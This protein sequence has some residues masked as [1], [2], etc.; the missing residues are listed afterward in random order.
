MRLFQKKLK[1]SS[2][3]KVTEKSAGNPGGMAG[4]A[5]AFGVRGTGLIEIVIGTA[6]ITVVLA[7]CFAAVNGFF[8]IGKKTSDR[9]AATYLAEEGVEAVRFIRDSGW[10]TIAGLSVDTPHYLAISP[11]II[12]IGSTPEALP[13][14]ER[15]VTFR[16]VYRANASD[17]I[18]ASTSPAGKSVDPN[19]K[20]VEVSV[21]APRSDV[22]VTLAAYLTNLWQE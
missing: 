8:L 17:D 11:A 19:T 20:L 13:D 15:T 3:R 21:Y 2:E 12:S 10:A 14:F 16:D 1:K 22:R 18:V 7:F 6:I 4:A 5:H 9:I